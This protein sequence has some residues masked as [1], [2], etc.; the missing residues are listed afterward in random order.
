MNLKSGYGKPFLVFLA[1]FAIILLSF[2]S[3]ANGRIIERKVRKLDD[4][5]VKAMN[6]YFMVNFMND[7]VV[8]EFIKFIN[9][10][11]STVAFEDDIEKGC[12]ELKLTNVYKLY[13]EYFYELSCDCCGWYCH[14]FPSK[15]KSGCILVYVDRKERL[16]RINDNISTQKLSWEID[17]K[18]RAIKALGAFLNDRGIDPK[19]ERRET[20]ADIFI[21]LVCLLN[22]GDFP[23]Q[24]ELLS[25]KIQGNKT[26]CD[27]IADYGYRRCQ[28]TIIFDSSNHILNAKCNCYAEN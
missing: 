23:Q 12:L 2:C 4:V 9:S 19:T 25:E 27:F 3:F 14:N 13:G 20:I 6:S 7:R 8:K 17:K 26:A 5:T 22:V 16:V 15:D 1:F 21:S 24:I 11:A 18:D 10:V 28:Y